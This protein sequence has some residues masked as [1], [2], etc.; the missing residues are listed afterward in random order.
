[1][2]I[3]RR[4]KILFSVVPSLVLLLLLALVE[5]SLRIFWPSLQRPFIVPTTVGG[6][7]LL[8]VNRRYLA[9]YFPPDVPLLP[10]LKPGLFRAQKDKK[11]YRIVCLGESSMFGT[12]YQM[13]ANIPGIIRKQLRHLYP[14]REFEVLNLGASAIN[15]NVIADLAKQV[16]TIE[17]D[18]VLLYVGHNEF[19]GPDG[20]GASFIERQVPGLT[21]IK[22]HAKELSLMALVERILTPKTPSGV[23]HEPNLMRQVSQEYTVPLESDTAER[24]FGIYE[25]NL[26]KIIILFRENNIPLIVSDVTSNLLFPP[27]VS[28]SIPHAPNARAEI[29]AAED[30]AAQQRAPEALEKLYRLRALDS[31]NAA[32]N[33]TI[34]TIKLKQGKVEPAR[35]YL[36]L[37]R[38]ND[39]LKFRAPERTNEITRNVCR[40]LGIPLVSSD[41]LFLFM[42]PGGVPG[43]ELFWEHLHP[44][45][46]GYFEIANLYLQKILE[47]RLLGNELPSSAT[48]R[49]LRFDLDS[50]GIPW[51]DLAFADLSMQN[52]THHW[53]FDNYSIH[54]VVLT[55]PGDR[56]LR[57]IATQVYTLRVG[58]EE[59]CLKSAFRFQALGQLRPAA[60]TYQ[61][62]IDENPYDFYAHYLLGTTLRDIGD[63][64]QAI[65]QL[66]HS[67][68]LKA[69]YPFSKIDL[70]LLEINEG[71][72]D[73]AIHLLTDALRLVS[74]QHEAT[75]RA[76]VLYGLAAA[77]ANKGNV[78]RAL[79][80]ID[81][82][83]ALAPGYTSAQQLRAALKRTHAP[84]KP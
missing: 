78:E 6:V 81:E 70:G 58:W 37:A 69:D 25:S 42:S 75:V 80:L 23:L 8:Q 15:S 21:A 3:S 22:Y 4:K 32:V 60:T 64:Q 54:P 61:A 62:L 14:D 41:S 82:A 12:P 53:P 44:T 33:F 17:P 63:D 45:A 77:H 73:T 18:L 46:R 7:E 9:K 1:M 38:D 13:T 57:G 27:F 55:E 11:A 36:R 76:T 40:G 72:F 20:A 19:Y 83:L 35:F 71:N 50:L 56:Q 67:V 24:I 59:G 31:T 29:H 65:F 68:Q 79:E 84:R 5:L 39:L 43:N 74:K 26:R 2:K 30:L 51:L 16:T 28:D 34:G 47:L 49:L 52:L 66:R 10:E 48:R